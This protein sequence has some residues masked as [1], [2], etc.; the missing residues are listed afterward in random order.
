MPQLFLERVG[1]TKF[2][3]GYHGVLH[4]ELSG[5]LLAAGEA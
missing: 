2:T 3:L 1:V 5:K 4:I